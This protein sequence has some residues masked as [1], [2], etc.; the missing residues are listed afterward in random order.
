VDVTYLENGAPRTV[1]CRV[2]LWGAPKH[3]ARHVIQGMPEEQRL[4]IG[5][6]GFHNISVMN[7]CYRRTIFDGAYQAWFQGLPVVDL[8]PADWVLVHGKAD[9]GRSQILSCDWPL[10]QGDRALLLDDQWVVEQCQETA[11]GFEKMFPGSLD[12]L[13]EIRVY[14]RA[15]SW[16]IPTPGYITRLRPVISR[17][18]GRVLIARSDQLDFEAAHESGVEMAREARRLL[19]A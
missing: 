3:I 7:L 11:R 2:C 9:P 19:A 4:A 15:H 14:V 16:V 8:L 17:P 13:E 12:H 5:R 1:R 10:R 18:V 6:M